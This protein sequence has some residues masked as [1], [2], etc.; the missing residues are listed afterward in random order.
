MAVLASGA[1]APS[2][3]RRPNRKIA[4]M[5]EGLQL[6][7]CEKFD[8]SAAMRDINRALQTAKRSWSAFNWGETCA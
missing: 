2:G 6:M 1:W 8:P 4:S 3:N 7:V 5:V